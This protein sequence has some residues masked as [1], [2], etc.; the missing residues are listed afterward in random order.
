MPAVL[1]AACCYCGCANA[2]P[3]HVNGCTMVHTAAARAAVSNAAIARS[4]GVLENEKADL[5][6]TKPQFAAK[7]ADLGARQQLRLARQQLQQLLTEVSAFEVRV[8]VE[9]QRVD[10]SRKVALHL[11]SQA[12]HRQK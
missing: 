11:Y 5:E 1:R 6:A 12:A 8:S 2:S 4:L 10:E 3:S 9:Q 7:H